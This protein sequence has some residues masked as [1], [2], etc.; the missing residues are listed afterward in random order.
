MD[1]PQVIT[2][3]LDRK[4]A[5]YNSPAYKYIAELLEGAKTCET[6]N[7]KVYLPITEDLDDIVSLIWHEI[8]DMLLDIECYPIDGEYCIDVIFG[9]D[10]VPF[11]DGRE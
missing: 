7:V 4:I 11:W 3:Y 9:G 10:Y 2:N 6:G 8:G 5:K 1:N